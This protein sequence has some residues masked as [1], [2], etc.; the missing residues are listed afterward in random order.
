MISELAGGVYLPGD[1]SRRCGVVAWGWRESTL[2]HRLLSGH[3]QH[4]DRGQDGRGLDLC[5]GV[6]EMQ[7]Q[8]I[9]IIAFEAFG[10]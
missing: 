10:G 3:P 4:I 9:C 1:N 7:I 8:L 2:H 5:N 6:I